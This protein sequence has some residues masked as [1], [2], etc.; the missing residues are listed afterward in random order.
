MIK[1]LKAIIRPVI[2]MDSKE[3]LEDIIQAYEIMISENR[4][5][6]TRLS[7]TV[8]DLRQEIKSSLIRVISGCNVAVKRVEEAVE[9]YKAGKP[10]GYDELIRTVT[11]LKN[12]QDIMLTPFLANLQVSGLSYDFVQTLNN[13]IETAKTVLNNKTAAQTNLISVNIGMVTPTSGNLISEKVS[14]GVSFVSM[15][16]SDGTKSTSLQGCWTQQERSG[17]GIL[18]DFEGN[19]FLV[20]QEGDNVRIKLLEEGKEQETALITA[21]ELA[22]V[23]DIAGSG[24]TAEKLQSM[25]SDINR[26]KTSGFKTLPVISVGAV[27][28]E[29]GAT[30]ILEKTDDGLNVIKVTIG[31]VTLV[32]PWTKENT[33][34]YGLLTDSENNVWRVHL[35]GLDIV[36]QKIDN[37]DDITSSNVVSA[38]YEEMLKTISEI[39]NL[40]QFMVE[41]DGRIDTLEKQMVS[42]EDMIS[43]VTDNVNA[44]FTKISD[45][46]NLVNA[47]GTTATVDGK[48][49]LQMVLDLRAE[50]NLLK[51]SSV[52]EEVTALNPAVFNYKG[53]AVSSQHEIFL[54]IIRNMAEKGSRDITGATLISQGLLGLTARDLAVWIDDFITNALWCE[55]I[56]TF[57][58]SFGID[59]D[60]FDTGSILGYDTGSGITKKITDVINAD[61]EQQL[62]YPATTYVFSDDKLFGGSYSMRLTKR[63]GLD[64]LVQMPE[65][66]SESQRETV[67]KTIAWYI[68]ASLDLV[69]KA[70]SL[71]FNSFSSK[72]S[73]IRLSGKNDS[74]VTFDKKVV[75]LVFDAWDAA[76][77]VTVP[78][79]NDTI[80]VSY[81]ALDSDSKKAAAVVFDINGNYYSQISGNNGIGI[82]S[83]PQTFDR[84]VCHAIATA[85][86]ACNISN[87]D[88]LP[89]WFKEGLASLVYGFDDKITDDV[90]ELLRSRTR[91]EKAFSSVIAD[92]ANWEN[93]KDP[94]ITG[95]LFLRYLISK[96]TAKDKEV[97]SYD[98]LAEGARLTKT[99][100]QN[101][102][103]SKEQNSM[104]ILDEGIMSVTDKFKTAADIR[105]SFLSALEKSQEKGEKLSAFLTRECNLSVYTDSEGKTQGYDIAGTWPYDIRSRNMPENTGYPSNVI[106]FDSQ[107]VHFKYVDGTLFM[108]PN[109]TDLTEH[110]QYTLAEVA[111][112]YLPTALDI[113]KESTGFSFNRKLK[114]GIIKDIDG[115]VKTYNTPFVF[116]TFDKNKISPYSLN[117]DDLVKTD[118][119]V[120][121]DGFV[122]AVNLTISTKYFSRIKDNFA[123]GISY[124]YPDSKPLGTLI[125]QELIKAAL[126]VNLTDNRYPL[127]FTNGFA[128]A[129]S[130]D[131]LFDKISDV[132]SDI[133]RTETALNLDAQDLNSFVDITDPVV[134]GFVLLHY[135]VRHT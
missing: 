3:R 69:E 14:R 59:L 48:N 33:Y 15:I 125:L 110:E 124:D 99:M 121:S 54:K 19:A 55:D 56:D 29:G 62:V 49:L 20:V 17:S 28:A 79:E 130:N 42:L 18:T 92:Y 50:V 25:I 100:L 41:P 66:L 31:G 39:S 45:F 98:G 111:D 5:S 4:E 16:F 11:D 12:V 32:G 47:V 34:G 61:Y 13:K 27:T 107:P 96:L 64:I 71:S 122:D 51:S 114:V 103:T 67:K 123:E 89:F 115:T 108:F 70:T 112:C 44:N 106:H 26:L 7:Q 38:D 102:A 129:V 87:Y 118:C 93:S 24:I 43:P 78:K 58:N 88:T 116:V 8:A 76:F 63:N 119:H 128:A 83:A 36:A 9:S 6:V 109:I 84:A 1:I 57:L 81:P 46:N 60:N 82:N 2:K 97:I 95:Y 104:V 10:D 94:A 131:D 52:T 86:F 77:G 40:A 120:R 80:T 105:N 35:N 113:I 73:K 74:F 68:P 21:D 132:L 53:E 85:V 22:A 126:A 101:M 133:R 117:D 75:V 90:K 37:T 134:A 135:F 91:L 65:Q 23:K 72:L 127:W 30:A